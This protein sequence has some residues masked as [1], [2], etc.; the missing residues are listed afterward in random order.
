MD[1]FLAKISD[2]CDCRAQEVS[3]LSFACSRLAPRL[4]AFRVSDRYVRYKP[5]VRS[6][7]KLAALILDSQRCLGGT[8]KAGRGQP[9][10]TRYSRFGRGQRSQFPGHK[11]LAAANRPVLVTN[12]L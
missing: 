7:W 9:R 1:H 5:G 11:N 3:Y 4:A 12:Q 6:L 2:V 8:G 10:P